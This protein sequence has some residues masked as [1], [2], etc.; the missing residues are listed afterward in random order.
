[1]KRQDVDKIA[2][3]DWRWYKKYFQFWRIAIG[4]PA[5]VNTMIR[6]DGNIWVLWFNWNDVGIWWRR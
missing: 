4:Y 5:V 6:D 3:E 1:M 2:D